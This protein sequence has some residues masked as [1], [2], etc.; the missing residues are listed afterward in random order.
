VNELEGAAYGF[1]ETAGDA[2]KG[3]ALPRDQDKDPDMFRQVEIAVESAAPET[4]GGFTIGA[5]VHHGKGLGEGETPA[6]DLDL[7]PHVER[8]DIGVATGVHQ[9]KV[10][11]EGDQRRGGRQGVL[12]Q[13]GRGE[14][15]AD[16]KEMEKVPHG[17]GS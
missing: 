2:G 1:F 10:P 5:A 9:A 11:G 8:R 3:V 15:Q 6:V 4:R 17:A 14:N 16:D 7:L 13:D 12:G